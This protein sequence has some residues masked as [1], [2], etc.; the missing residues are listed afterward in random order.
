V[1]QEALEREFIYQEIPFKSQPVIEIKYKGKPLYKKYQPD[2]TCYDEV[3]VEIKAISNLSGIEEAQLINYLNATGLKVGLL[4]N[5]ENKSLE[6]RNILIGKIGRKL[7]TAI[8]TCRGNTIRII[9][10]RRSREKETK[11]YEQ[12]EVS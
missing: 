6:D 2:F 10:V 12:K 5:F 4:I 7:W 1:N 11:L 9:S 8:Y 3:I